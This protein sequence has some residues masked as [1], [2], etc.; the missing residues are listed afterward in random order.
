LKT[1]LQD[2]IIERQ[3]IVLNIEGDI[4]ESDLK[5]LKQSIVNL[6]KTKIGEILD[7]L[8]SELVPADVHINLDSLDIKLPKI[9][10]GDFKNTS[11]LDHQFEKEFRALAY[12]AIKEKV[13]KKTGG[14]LESDGKKLKVSKWII[15]ENFL[16]HGHYPSWAS[17]KNER[18]EEQTSELQTT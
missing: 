4:S 15:L 1:S 16:D 11:E 8:F 6:Y 17:G 14:K 10:I 2:H 13:L 12:K 5:S 3:N 7:K 18:S 9:D